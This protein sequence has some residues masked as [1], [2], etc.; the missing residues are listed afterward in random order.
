M[1][2]EKVTSLDVAK[3]IGVSQSAVSRVFTPG[4]SVSNE[5]E[6]RVLKAAN[7]LGY[8]P[9][10]LARSLNTGKSR[11]IGLVVSYLDNQFYPNVLESLSSK[12]QESGYHI[13]IFI[14]SNG[15]KNLDQVLNEILDYQVDGIIMASVELSSVISKKID[16]AG[17][18]VIL[19]N[20]SLDNMRFSSVT[21]NNYNGGK[22]IANFL[23]KGGHRKISHIAG[24]EKASTQRDRETGFIDGLKETGVDLFSR[25]VGN[26]VL[27]E[28][29][30]ATRKMFSSKNSPDAVFVANDHMAFAVMD[31]LRIELGLKIPEDVSV[32]G[33]DDVK[34]S[35][36]PSYDLTTVR[37]PINNMVD[38]TISL[39]I[40]QLEGNIPAK[41]IEVDAE[42]IVR[43]SAKLPRNNFN[44]RS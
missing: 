12:L 40:S 18:P 24:N 5:M 25:E 22:Q 26:F 4:A 31:V 37:Q 15:T 39:L 1:V 9:N 21:S 27:D 34:I 3:K 33:Y 38:R 13:L 32:V 35:S 20:R 6:G 29:S 16:S 10:M 17:I 42:L 36:W 43:S 14:A 28:A 19:L 44:K 30:S 7:E 23:I 11:I 2:T 8:R 41:Q